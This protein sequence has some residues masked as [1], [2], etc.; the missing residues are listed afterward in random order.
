[1]AAW[2]ACA[3]ACGSKEKGPRS[4]E[5]AARVSR[6]LLKGPA[7]KDLRSF[8]R[9]GVITARDP[10]CRGIMMLGLE[11]PEGELFAAFELA[12]GCPMVKGFAVG[13]TIFAAPAA[14]WFAGRI[15]DAEVT[16]QMAAGFQRLVEA[17]MAARDAN[18]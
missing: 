10:L 8:S 16:A 13:R 18:S 1:M 11:A 17:W 15:D 12:K 5:K 9:P 7:M 6:A 14:A 4:V 2:P 3:L